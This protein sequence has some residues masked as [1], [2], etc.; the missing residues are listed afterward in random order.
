VTR[1]CAVAAI[2]AL[3]WTPAAAHAQT[4]QERVDW[5]RQTIDET[6]QRWFDAQHTAAQIDAEIADLE[7]RI[8]D[9]E[10]RA[11]SAR[12]VATARALE[13]YKGVTISYGD[14]IGSTW[15]ES[16]RRAQL[17][18]GANAKNIDA[19]EEL[20][21][22]VHDLKARHKELVGRRDAQRKALDEVADQRGAL[23]AQLAQLK[24]RIQTSA[25][26]ALARAAP[27]DTLSAP[28]RPDNAAPAVPVIPGL[29]AATIAHRRGLVSPHHSDPFLVCTRA[30]ESSGRYGVVSP[31]GYYGA[32][33]FLPSTWD[34]TA[35]HAGRDDLVG[36][37]PSVASE[38]DQ[39]ELAWALYMWQGNG[40]W[41]GRC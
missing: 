20:T 35:L 9:A 37:L 19:I 22:A 23:D 41:N 1:L 32:Y 7:G 29:A 30:H 5:M 6:A 21:S 12:R 8:A 13:M 25:S 14:V 34:S 3:A 40:P 27:S 15:I 4:P 17:I 28:T 11:K 16:A 36:I 18:D 26:A 38:Y 2:C 24:A 31:A 33:Q 39:D 10:A